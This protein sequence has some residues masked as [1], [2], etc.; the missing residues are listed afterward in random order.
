MFLL[1]R[2]FLLSLLFLTSC[3]HNKELEG[4]SSSNIKKAEP[5]KSWEAKETV[6]LVVKEDNWWSLEKKTG[7][8][9]T[10]LKS[11]NKQSRLNNI[12]RLKIPAKRYHIVKSGETLLKIANIYK[13]KFSEI[14]SLNELDQPFKIFSGLKLKVI[15]LREMKKDKMTLEDIKF[16]WPINGE[17]IEGFGLQDN[18]KYNNE[19]IIKASGEVVASESGRVV[20][21]GNEIGS[22]INLTIIKHENGFFSS[23]A[24]LDQV[25]VKKGDTINKGQKLGTVNEK[26]S[27]G[28]RKNTSSLDPLKFLARNKRG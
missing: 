25:F 13:M 5:T 11:F 6:I 19:I 1:G 20:Y 10:A 21:A 27:F 17:V 18:G 8:P 26:L 15:D 4:R 3:H 7:I 9:T 28:I 22:Y 12:K 2:F 24:N 23:Y 16:S 14:V